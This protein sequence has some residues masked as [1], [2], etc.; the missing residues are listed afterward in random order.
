LP[1]FNDY[2]PQDRIPVQYSLHFVGAPTEEPIRRDF[3]FAGSDDPTSDFLSSLQQHIGTFGAIIVWNKSFESQVNDAIARR[4]PEARL[5]VADF[6]DR[7]QVEAAQA[8]ARVNASR[9]RG[10]FFHCDYHLV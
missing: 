8:A 3:L 10:F 4:V 9:S 6:Y 5:Y 2:S 1:R 7:W